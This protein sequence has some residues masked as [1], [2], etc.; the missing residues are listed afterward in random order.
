MKELN[1]ITYNE[2]VEKEEEKTDYKLINKDQEVD[3]GEEKEECEEEEN[4]ENMGEQQED[5]G[6]DGRK[7]SS[8]ES[9]LKANIEKNAIGITTDEILARKI[10]SKTTTNRVVKPEKD[11]Q[12]DKLS[13]VS[14]KLKF[15]LRF[16]FFSFNQGFNQL[17][18]IKIP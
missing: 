16:L 14:G 1:Q 13:S 15:I 2:K 9:F 8:D 11:D 12:N 7:N 4:N 6:Q 5:L 10:E 17:A 18:V 3:L